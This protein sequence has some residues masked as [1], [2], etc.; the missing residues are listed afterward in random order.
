MFNKLG[1]ALYSDPIPGC[2]MPTKAPVERAMT[3]DALQAHMMA[4]HAFAFEFKAI[5]AISRQ[6]II[7]GLPMPLPQCFPHPA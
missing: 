1:K 2:T 6:E 5:V 3:E 7:R 4:Y